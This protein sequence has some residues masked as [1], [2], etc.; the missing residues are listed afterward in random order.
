VSALSALRPGH[1][2]GIGLIAALFAT[3]AWTNV[4]GL[5]GGNTSEAKRLDS[6]LHNHGVNIAALATG[7]GGPAALL[8]GGQAVD[9]AIKQSASNGQ[10]KHSEVSDV[11]QCIHRAKR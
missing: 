8:N 1:W 6:C 2:I 10:I 7:A 4:F 11:I 9:Q 5:L 3:G